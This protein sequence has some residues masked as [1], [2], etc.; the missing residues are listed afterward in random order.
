MRLLLSLIP[1]LSAPCFAGTLIVVTGAA[2]EPK[3][4][5]AF[6][7]QSEAWLATKHHAVCSIGL[8]SED[9]AKHDAEKLKAALAGSTGDTW[10]VLNGHGTWDG[11]VAKFNLRGPDVSGEELVA[12]C[13]PVKD[14]LVIINTAAASAPFLA[15]LA[16]PGRLVISSTKS[17]NE[18]NFSHFGRFLAESLTDT[19]SDLD[20]DGAASALELFLAASQKTAEF[21]KNEQRLATEHPL[22]EDNGDGKGTPA[23]WFQGLVAKSRAKDNAAVDGALARQIF[24]QISPQEAKLTTEQ[25]ERRTLLEAQLEALKGKKANLEEKDYLRQLEAVLRELAKL[26]LSK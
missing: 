25:K 13:A 7:K 21:Y 16:A 14:Q 24:L 20:M 15:K 9:A 3:Y 4:A 5:E 17:G 26:T 18:Q 10:L 11:K 6:K 1:L 8:D 2:G 12:W 22:L 23:E 19:K